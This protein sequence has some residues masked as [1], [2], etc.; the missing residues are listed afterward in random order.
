[1]ENSLKQ[2]KKPSIQVMN[3]LSILFILAAAIQY[4]YNLTLENTP[5]YLLITT[6]ISL[7]INVLGLLQMFERKITTPIK[8]ARRYL[9]VNILTCYFTYVTVYNL[10]FFVAA[11]HHYYLDKYWYVGFIT[12]FVCSTSHVLSLILMSF[13]PDWLRVDKVIVIIVLKVIASLIY[14]QK[15]IE[16]IIIP[17][18]ADSH[19]VFMVS[20]IMIFA[21]NFL[22]SQY[23]LLY[24]RVFT[25]FNKL[26]E[27]N[28]KRYGVNK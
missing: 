15:I 28:K 3:V 24:G 4:H 7:V 16:Y 6:A 8:Q 10:Y 1:M 9:I 20:I 14:V 2:M 12:L 19:F 11:E 5:K 17:N 21:C 27:D 25:D 23:Y 13:Y 18:I 26:S 22:V